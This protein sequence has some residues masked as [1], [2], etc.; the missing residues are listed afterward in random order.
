MDAM[1]WTIRLAMLLYAAALALSLARRTRA[2]RLPWTLACTLLWAHV[3]LAYHHVHGWSQTHALRHTAEQTFALTGVR[4]GAGVYLNYA[5]MLVWAADVAWWWI[6]GHAAYTR[7]PRWVAGL[8]HG[9]L[10][11]MAV[12]AAIVFAP[13]PTRAAGIAVAAVLV[14]VGIAARA[15]RISAIS[16]SARLTQRP[17]A[18]K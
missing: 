8:V 5:T 11:F 3:G 9:L 4:S 7:R 13:P 15:A 14:V 18:A 1:F 10:L 12:N 17:R 2:A 16:R 6:V